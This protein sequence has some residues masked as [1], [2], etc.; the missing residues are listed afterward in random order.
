MWVFRTI[1]S[2]DEPREIFMAECGHSTRAS[3]A[4]HAKKGFGVHKRKKLRSTAF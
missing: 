1:E 4:T 2:K 3:R